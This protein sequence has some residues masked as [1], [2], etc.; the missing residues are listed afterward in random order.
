MTYAI[1]AYVL[2]GILWIVYLISLAAR[3]GRAKSA[4]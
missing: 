1:L 3:L 2:S 4:R